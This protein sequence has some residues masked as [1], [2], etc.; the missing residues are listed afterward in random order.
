MKDIKISFKVH[1][2]I[3]RRIVELTVK[4]GK[5]VTIKDYVEG[6]VSKDVKKGKD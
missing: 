4:T 1:C 3:K 5:T 2:I 6:L